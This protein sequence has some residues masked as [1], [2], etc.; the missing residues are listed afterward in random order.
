[1]L[2]TLKYELKKETGINL[3]DNV[4]VGGNIIKMDLKE[5][6]IVA[7]FVW[8]RVK[9]IYERSGNFCENSGCT[10]HENILNLS[11]SYTFI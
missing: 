7:V 3:Y 9:F 8:I 11:T 6:R 10:K 1:V 5:I 2:H 4:N